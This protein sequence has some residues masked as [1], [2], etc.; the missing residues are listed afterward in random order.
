MK[1]ET[2]YLNLR[3]FTFCKVKVNPVNQKKHIVESH[4]LMGFIA[5]LRGVYGDD[6]GSSNY[7]NAPLLPKL[8]INLGVFNA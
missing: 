1:K 6:L 4:S 2:W 8:S 7:R 3:Q 5:V